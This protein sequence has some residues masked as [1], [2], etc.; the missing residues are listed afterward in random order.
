MDLARRVWLILL[1]ASGNGLLAADEA[2][3]PPAHAKSAPEFRLPAPDGGTFEL[4]P[5]STAP[6]TVI[7]FLGTE[8][9]LARLYG[10]RLAELHRAFGP[11]GVRFVGINSNSQ[12]SPDEV[13]A[14]VREYAIPFPVVKD[15]GQKVADLFGARR[16]PE[17]YVV[18]RQLTVR[19]HGRVDDQYQPGVARSQPGRED[20]RLALED[21]LA[22]R[23]IQVASTDFTGC[24]IGR[25]RQAVAGQHVTFCKQVS[26]ILNQH[27]VECHRPGEIGPFSLT[28][29]DDVT[30]WGETLLESI[31]A[32]RM[33]PWHASPDHGHFAN[34]R[35]MP[36]ADKQVLRDWVAGGMPLGDESELPSSAESLAGSQLMRTPDLVVDMRDRPF[37]V[38]ATGTVEYQYFVVDPGFTEDRWISAAQVL[39]GNRAVV[40]HCI[41]FIRPPDGTGL[42]GVGLLTGYVPG[43]RNAELKP[44]RARRVPAGSKLVFQ[45][46]YTPNGTEQSDLTRIALNWMP[47]KEVTHQ[48]YSLVAIEQEFEIPPQT[49]GFP[50]HARVRRLPP[51]GELL[52]ITPHMHVRGQSFQA[53]SRRS[54]KEEVLLD[55]PRY[56]FNW[57]HA[58][59]LTT[60]LDLSTIDSLE[61]TA[62]FDNSSRNPANPDPAEFVTW[63]D[64]T[65]EE[66]A[67]AFFEVSE[68]LSRDG[69]GQP[70]P[71]PVAATVAKPAPEQDRAAEINAFAADFLDRFDRD[72][73][74]IVERTETPL[75]FRTYG[76][77]E[78]DA[79]GDG[80]LT[81]DEVEAAARQRKPR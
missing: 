50:V 55:V 45:M 65:W 17:V 1:L 62:K 73:N 14:Y 69:V 38:P 32:G 5:Q 2:A 21:L 64:Q 11:R 3:K 29:Y 66:M 10:P 76:F 48:V 37:R 43:Q 72:R 54:G 67:L 81:R 49:A 20:L 41:V 33:P 12:D 58:Y 26:R 70:S 75:V 9:P 24:L 80:G 35:H 7:C 78:I 19:Y 59:Q 27:C 51:Q 8:C 68:P 79:N 13:A 60:P 31:D 4:S 39:P 23:P 34:A 47:A 46:H 40:H 56:D 16:S 63:G 36:E 74:G 30:G 18:D 53:F 44:G 22:G 52:A 42:R 61:F 28:Q 57:Q 6:F 15:P 25:S 77:R 71:R